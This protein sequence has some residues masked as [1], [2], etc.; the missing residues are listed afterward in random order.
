[1]ARCDLSYSSSVAERFSGL[2]ID[3]T[4]P[5]NVCLPAAGDGQDKGKK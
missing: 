4:T 2:K 1:M 3:K 5:R